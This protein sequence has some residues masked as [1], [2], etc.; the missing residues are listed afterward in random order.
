MLKQ[1][2]V[3]FKDFNN[4]TNIFVLLIF[5]LKKYLNVINKKIK[6]YVIYKDKKLII[7]NIY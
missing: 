1:N 5:N 4:K 3:Y 2:F 7:K 6:N